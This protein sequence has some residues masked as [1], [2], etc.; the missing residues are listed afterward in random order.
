LATTTTSALSITFG[1][2]QTAFS[3]TCIGL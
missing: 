3:F 2:A 1:T